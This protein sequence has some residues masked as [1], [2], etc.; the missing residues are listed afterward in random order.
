M[1]RRKTAL[2]LCP[3]LAIGSFMALFF[4]GVGLYSYKARRFVLI[5][6]VDAVRFLIRCGID[7]DEANRIVIYVINSGRADELTDY[8]QTLGGSIHGV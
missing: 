5:N 8:I 1:S 7:I 4:M 6:A 2:F 3:F